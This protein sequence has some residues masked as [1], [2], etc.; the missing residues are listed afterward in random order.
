MGLYLWKK[1]LWGVRFSRVVCFGCA[2]Y[3]CNM[4]ESCCSFCCVAVTLPLSLCGFRRVAVVFFFFSVLLLPCRPHFDLCI[5]SAP[6]G[7][8]APLQPLVTGS[9]LHP[10]PASS[11]PSSSSPS[12]LPSSSQSSVTGLPRFSF[13]IPLFP[14]NSF[15]S[16]SYGEP[17]CVSGSIFFFFFLPPSLSWPCILVSF[18][19]AL[20]MSQSVTSNI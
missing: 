8:H 3:K 1:S 10:S 9:H 16:F 19:F 14:H 5:N 13:F 18:L 12:T 17:L 6:V 4:A 2:L 15:L 20:T 7:H 11:S